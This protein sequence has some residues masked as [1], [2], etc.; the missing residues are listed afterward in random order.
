[1]AII[2]KDRVKQQ[3]TTTG[4]GTY[5]LSGSFAGFDAFT[6]IGDGN[7]TYYC[8]TDGT[9]FEIGRG[10]FTASGTTL[11]RAEILSSSNSNTAV[12]W[13]SGT[14]TI[15]CTQPAEKAVFLNASDNIELAD[16]VNITFGAAADLKIFH[17]G[18]ASVIQDT[19]TGPL[20]LRTSQTHIQNSSANETMASFYSNGAVELFYNNVKTFETLSTGATVTGSLGINTSSPD[21]ALHVEGSALIDAYN[22]G[23]EEG[24]FFREGFS[25][26]N[27]YNLSILTYDHSSSNV[28]PDGLSI[29]AYDGVSFNVG[30]N[31]R[32]EVVRIVG[33]TGASSGDVQIKTGN[34]ELGD[35]QEL[36]IGDGTDLKIWHQS[37]SG[38][39][40][41]QETG[42]G[43]LK[44]TGNEI[45]LL[46][47]ANSEYKAKFQDDGAVE[48]YFNSVKKF[49]TTNTGT[50]VTGDLKITPDGL[51][52]SYGSDVEGLYIK[53]ATADAATDENISM[54]VETSP[55]SGTA[56]KAF[57]LTQ[58]TSGD[59]TVTNLV[60]RM[61]DA[62]TNATTPD[63]I[64]LDTADSSVSAN[65]FSLPDDGEIRLGDGSDLKIYHDGSGSYISEQGTGLLY[66]NST[67]GGWIRVGSGGETSAYFKGNGAVELYYDNVKKFETTADGVTITS[68]DAGDADA[69]ILKLNRNSAS[70]A[71]NDDLGRI[72][73]NGKN[74]AGQDVTYATIFTQIADASDGTEDARIKFAPVVGGSLD[75]SMEIK[76]GGVAINGRLDLATGGDIRFEGATSDNFETLLSPGDPTADRTITLPDRSGLVRVVDQQ[77][78]TANLAVGWHTIAVFQG[79]D[80]S[81]QGPNQR[82]HAKFSLI[83]VTASRHQALTF[84][85]QSLYSKD[86]GLQIIGN[87]TF[88]TDVVT[89]IRIKESTDGNKTYAGA[90]IQV[91]VADATNSL[92]LFLDEANLDD[93][94]GGVSYGNVILKTGVA[95]ASDPGDVGYSTAGY[96]TFAES[97][98]IGTDSIE[99]GGIGVTGNLLTQSNIVLEG[100]TADSKETVITAVDP[101]LDRTITLP[102]ATGTVALQN[103]NAVL[104]NTTTVS[105]AVSS[106]DFG[107]SLIT[108]DFDNYLLVVEDL[109]VSAATDIRLRLGTANSADTSNIYTASVQWRGRALSSTTNANQN[110][111]GTL[112]DGNNA[113]IIGGNGGD[114][115]TAST[116][117]T[118]FTIRLNNLRSTT[119]HKTFSG[120]TGSCVITD[121]TG[122]NLNVDYVCSL[123]DL[124][125]TYQ[126]TSAVNFIRVYESDSSSQISG[127]T[128]SLYGLKT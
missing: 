128:F 111:S 98:Q 63:D 7:E 59:A 113:I 19:G 99:P 60:L 33:G 16:N 112:L 65:I 122:A 1:M 50:Q 15:F 103:G 84:Y 25:D 90:V 42:G 14:R 58:V 30:S 102:D 94:E 121:I 5:T 11:S 72:E 125:G 73:F 48:L 43:H 28:S 76:F 4:T 117:S 100:A 92:I 116:A 18:T 52:G 10:T 57:E 21:E 3:T 85:A 79:R 110:F 119:F 71:D 91:Y 127:G 77:G 89:A 62:F 78:M 45:H 20:R 86:A 124:I 44:I 87:S 36:R 2:L 67:P 29:N 61:G 54:R 38:N 82:F 123:R 22:A 47:A 13:T 9:D 93:N 49:E 114:V 6:E 51:T 8:C 53:S 46:N 104:L 101:T 31:S 40:F 83:D 17:S 24:I 39:S 109:T 66:I 68:T 27:K 118:D 115:S 126:T 75:T 69:P 23:Q 97:V 55:S 26:S 96:S 12:N 107:S 34:L 70:P 35:D 81:P 74:D 88:S 105:S 108:D 80:D 64:V 41:I 106:V 56:D 37:S 120:V 32:N 95:D